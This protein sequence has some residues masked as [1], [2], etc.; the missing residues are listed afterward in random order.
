[1]DEDDPPLDGVWVGMR[2]TLRGAGEEVL[3]EECPAKNQPWFN[4]ECEAARVARADAWAC[5]VTDRD[6]PVL[7]DEYRAAHKKFKKPMRRRLKQEATNARVTRLNE[8][9]AASNV[10]RFFRELIRRF[11]GGYSPRQGGA[12]GGAA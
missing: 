11:K 5:H 1:M 9:N 12:P 3:H 4:E 2:A 8:D 10:R 7:H 6:D